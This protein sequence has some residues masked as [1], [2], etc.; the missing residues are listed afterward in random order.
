MAAKL[1]RATRSERLEHQL[2]QRSEQPSILGLKGWAVAAE[3]VGNFAGRSRHDLSAIGRLLVLDEQIGKRISGAR[4]T[5]GNVRIGC[6]GFEACM[7]ENPLNHGY[8]H[9]SLQ[10]VGG[11]TVAQDVGRAGC[12]N[13][14]NPFG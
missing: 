14:S 12:F 8:I 4:C 13:S 6:R 5:G 10:A 3:D 7:P 1:R 11:V 9:A 2:M